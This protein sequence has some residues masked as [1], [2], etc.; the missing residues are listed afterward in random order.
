MKERLEILSSWMKEHTVDVDPYHDGVLE[1]I[2]K[3][4]KQ[5]TI[6]AIG[7][8]LE[9]ILSMDDEQIKNELNNGR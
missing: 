5:E 9:E 4:E 2:I 1:T 6:Q 8:L 3:H 7:R